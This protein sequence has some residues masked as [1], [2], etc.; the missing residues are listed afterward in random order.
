M[1]ASQQHHEQ[2]PSSDNTSGDVLLMLRE[3]DKLL[4]R[5]MVRIERIDKQL[6]REMYFRWVRYAFF[7]LILL[8]SVVWVTPYIVEVY[9]TYQTFTQRIT[10][11]GTNSVFELFN[12]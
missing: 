6:R 2:R 8:L 1:V 11:F 7:G 3:Q 5:L 4:K 12:R 10:E 9:T